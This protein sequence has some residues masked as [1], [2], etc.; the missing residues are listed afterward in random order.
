MSTAFHG[1]YFVIG[2]LPKSAYREESD[3][4]APAR[5]TNSQNLCKAQIRQLLR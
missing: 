5:S 1:L 3:F 2:H 4:Q